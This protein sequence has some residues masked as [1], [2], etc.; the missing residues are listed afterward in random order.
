MISNTHRCQN[1]LMS[2]LSNNCQV[3][4]YF[5][6]SNFMLKWLY[7]CNLSQLSLFCPRSLTL[8]P[9]RQLSKVY[10]HIIIWKYSKGIMW[11]SRTAIWALHH[12]FAVLAQTLPILPNFLSHI[13]PAHIHMLYVTTGILAEKPAGW[14]QNM[15]ITYKNM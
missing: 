2:P 7:S 14:I 4:T 1:A 3:T 10:D 15:P 5:L 11:Q 9:S 12:T 8:F 13:R 6:K